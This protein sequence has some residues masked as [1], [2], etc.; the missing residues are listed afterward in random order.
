MF[1]TGFP[2]Y[3]STLKKLIWLKAAVLSESLTTLT[4]AIVSFI[5]SKVKP[6][7]S[8]VVTITPQ[9]SGTGDPSPTNIRSITGFTEAK[10]FIKDE[11]D[12]SA[13]PTKTISWQSSAGTVYG[14]TLTINEDG[15]VDLVRTFDGALVMPAS[16]SWGWSY[17]SNGGYF[18]SNQFATIKKGQNNVVT[19][20]RCSMLKPTAP[21]NIQDLSINI[22]AETKPR[23]VIKDTSLNGDL[24][25]FKTKYADAQIAYERTTPTTYHLDSIDQLQTLLGYNNIWVD[26]SDNI[27]VT[28]PENIVV[29]L[30][31]VGIG[32][33]DSMKLTS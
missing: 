28:L 23:V 31:K 10:I 30:P 33:A 16:W 13:T 26:C 24:N 19:T 22:T 14:G 20:A 32:K 27:S 2:H 25:A 11:Y 1:D 15:S 4:G 21:N 9:Q 12:A 6:I 3:W 29:S 5:A 8:L 7:N 18:R 17:Y